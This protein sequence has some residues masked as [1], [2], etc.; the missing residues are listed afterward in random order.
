MNGREENVIVTIKL[1]IMIESW[2]CSVLF[3]SNQKKKRKKENLFFWVSDSFS[4]L[5]S[6]EVENVHRVECLGFEDILLWRKALEILDILL[7]LL[8]IS[9]QS[10]G[11]PLLEIPQNCVTPLLGNSRTKN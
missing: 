7:Y 5:T 2:S 3:W 6:I 11:S 10:K 9:R 1:T 8:G 4:Y